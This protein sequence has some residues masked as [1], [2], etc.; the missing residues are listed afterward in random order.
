MGREEP[1]LRQLTVC[2]SG[3]TI[4]EII[5]EECAQAEMS[6]REVTSGSRRSAVSRTRA[7]IGYR[8]REE[9]GLSAAESA[10]HLGVAPS[11]IT[12]AIERMVEG[13]G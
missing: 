5:D 6:P 11:S 4:A 7:L 13:T 9:L 8:S 3:G 2:R 12:R 1:Q 10:R